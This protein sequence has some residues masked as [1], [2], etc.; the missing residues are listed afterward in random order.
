MTD[1]F[2][3]LVAIINGLFVVTTRVI[4]AKLGAYVSSMGS[5]FWNHFVGFLFILPIAI[6]AGKEGDLAGLSLLLFLGG[7]IGSIYVA[8]N[9]VVFP[10]LGAMKA[11]L[12]V[13]AGQVAFGTL[14]DLVQ[15]RL[16]NPGW[17][18]LGVGLVILGVWLG[19]LSRAE[20]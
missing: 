10:K 5:S 7:L 19:N 16:A 20:T 18:T 8:I 4:I 9:N 15:G 14:I 13:I 12:F 6:L 17:T 1:Y 11:T 3:A 2:M